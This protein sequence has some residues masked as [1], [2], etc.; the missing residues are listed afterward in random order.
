[1][2]GGKSSYKMYLNDN[3]VGGWYGNAEDFLG[4]TPSIYLDGHSAT[5]KTLYDVEIE[6]G[7]MLKIIG[8]PHGI[9]PAPLDYVA[10]LP[11]GIVD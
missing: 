6:S 2:Y 9:E 8:I 3:M 1:M 7:D 11:K 10:V 5:R 4:Y